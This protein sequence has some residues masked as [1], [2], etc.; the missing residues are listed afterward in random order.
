MTKI[1]LHI[2]LRHGVSRYCEHL[3]TA[4]FVIEVESMFIA[5]HVK[6]LVDIV[7]AFY[8]LISSHVML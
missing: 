1:I 6:A 2:F 3:S 8:V 5:E 7:L 4:K